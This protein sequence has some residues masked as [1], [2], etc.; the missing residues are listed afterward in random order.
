[1]II[2]T[3]G[4]DMERFGGFYIVNIP[5]HYPLKDVCISRLVGANLWFENMFS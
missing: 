2:Y 5:S 3:P 4:E 1:M